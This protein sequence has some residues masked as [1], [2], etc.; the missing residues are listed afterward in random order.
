MIPYS[1]QNNIKYKHNKTEHHVFK[2][3][4]QYFLPVIM[5]RWIINHCKNKKNMHWDARASG[6]VNCT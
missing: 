1:L 2:I 3:Q 5:K 6:K 4:Q